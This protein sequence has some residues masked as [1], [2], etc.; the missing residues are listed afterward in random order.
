MYF[1]LSAGA[2]LAGGY[3]LSRLVSLGQAENV[4]T[5]VTDES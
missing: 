3:V 1:G 5:A 4:G 2:L